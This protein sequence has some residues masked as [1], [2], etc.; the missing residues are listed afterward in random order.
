LKEIN[1]LIKSPLNYVGGKYKLLPQILPLFPQ[2]I[3]TFVDLFCGGANVGVNVKASRIICNDKEQVVIDFL[4]ACRNHTSEEMVYKIENNINT[5]Q[6]SKTNKEGYLNIREDYN[7]GSR[8]WDMFYAMVTHG[9]N[10]SIRFNSKNEFNIAFGA[11]RSWFSPALRKKFIDF[12][13]HLKTLDIKF[14]NKD[15]RD[16]KIMNLKEGD[17]V[18]LDPPYFIT[19]ANYNENGGWTKK[20][21]R[22]LYH[23]LDYLNLHKVKFA[24]SNVTFHK[25][26]QND[27]LI[28]WAKRYNTY[29]LNYSYGNSN[30]HTKDKSKD[31]SQEVLITNY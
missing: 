12:V 9:F 23:M 13:D 10:Y 5:Y 28:E 17:F 21:E 3:N 20:D 24:L 15:Y 2:E 1:K 8:S 26:K 4:Q 19:V 11:N 31:S 7:K 25:G 22:E 29:N 30:Y 27:I 14:T 16:L 6:L 18:Y